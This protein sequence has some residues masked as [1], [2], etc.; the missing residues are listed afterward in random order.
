MF[1]VQWNHRNI[2]ILELWLVLSSLRIYYSRQKLSIMTLLQWIAYDSF[3]YSFAALQALIISFRTCKSGWKVLSVPFCISVR[4]WRHVMKCVL[5]TVSV[6][7]W[8]G[9]ISCITVTMYL[10]FPYDM[11]NLTQWLQLYQSMCWESI[12]IRT[13]NVFSVRVIWVAQLLKVSRKVSDGGCLK[14]HS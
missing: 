6:T 9:H 14:M 10:C 8:P 3:K 4:R 11:V 13:Y 12:K 2:C 7:Q 1:S 5:V